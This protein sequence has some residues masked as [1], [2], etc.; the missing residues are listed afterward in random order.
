MLILKSEQE[1]RKA[2][3]TIHIK[4]WTYAKNEFFGPYYDFK[5]RSEGNKSFIQFKRAYSEDAKYS[6]L[7]RFEMAINIIEELFLNE[8]R[9]LVILE[10]C[11]H[12]LELTRDEDIK[13]KLK[14]FFSNM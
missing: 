13:E 4:E 5:E 7:T 3:G 6:D 11:G 14:S 8:K 1:E 12:Q 2:Y 9:E 10:I